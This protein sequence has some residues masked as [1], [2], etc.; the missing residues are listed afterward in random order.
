MPKHAII[1]W[2]GAVI[3]IEDYCHI[4]YYRQRVAHTIRV[5]NCEYLHWI[6][7]RPA[8][9]RWPLTLPLPLV[10]EEYF[11][12]IDVLESVVLYY[13]T[14]HAYGRRHRRV[15]RVRPYRIVELGGGFG[16]WSITAQA[17]LRQLWRQDLPQHDSGEEHE[18]RDASAEP[19]RFHATLVEADASKL[20]VLNRSL[21][22]N[23]LAKKARVLHAAVRN[24]TQ[25]GRAMLVGQLGYYGVLTRSMP[26]GGKLSGA[27]PM[28]APQRI[29]PTMNLV[30]VLSPLPGLV[31][32]LDVDI[33]GSEFTAFDE[34]AMAIV[35]AKVL[36]VHFGTHNEAGVSVRQ[37]GAQRNDVDLKAD[38]LTRL[39]LRERALAQTFLNHGW[40]PR[41]M[42]A[43]SASCES[44][45]HYRLTP[46][47]SICMADGVL[48]F[49][50]PRHVLPPP[51]PGIP[52]GH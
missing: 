16:L 23:G 33:Q 3:A 37:Y 41:W 50:N 10:S 7:M 46:L 5:Q 1:D 40:T 32:M 2:L 44:Q 43:Q 14:I 6:S 31:D 24:G 49:S 47:G 11:E 13:R 36:F 20:P 29:V 21:A 42:V 28:Q 8:D 39:A 38:P 9:V 26:D 15:R 4:S 52:S 17:A 51:W 35:N 12:Y 19:P 45:N 25:G 18:N 48:S 22:R 30:E 27:T 34:A